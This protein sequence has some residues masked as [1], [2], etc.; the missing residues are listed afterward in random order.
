[1]K[2]RLKSAIVGAAALAIAGSGLAAATSALAAGP[3]WEPD[4]N[5]L[6]A[7]IFYDAAGNVLTGGT[8][9]SHIADFA[10]A[11]TAVPSDGNTYT[12]ANLVFAN[13]APSTPTGS[14][15][16]GAGSLNTNFPNTTAPAP[17][18][19][20]GFA[21]PVVTLGA[22]DGNLG[23]F[24]A[25]HTANTVAGFVDMY[26]VR[27]FATGPGGATTSPGYWE[28]DI[29][30]TRNPST[31]AITGWTVVFPTIATTTTSIS[32]TPPSPQTVGTSV[33]LNSTVTPAENGTV[34]F[35]DGATP[36]GTP[37]AV[38][39]STPNASVSAGTPAAGDHPYTAKFTPTGGTLV[40]G[41]TSSVLTYHIG[42]P[43]IT[44][45]T[46][47][48]V[49]PNTTPQFGSVTFTANITEADSPVTAGLAGSVNFEANGSSL[50]IVSTNDGT[51]GE[52]KL[53]DGSVALAPSGTPYNITAVFTP[54]NSAYSGST[55]GPLPLT[56]TQSACP[57]TPVPGSS[58]TDTQNV[59]VTVSAGSLTITTPYTAAKPFVI[60]AP[61]L[62]TAGTFLTSSAQFPAAG[63]PD[64]VVSSTLAS[65]PNWTVA[66]SGT[67]LTDASS[68]V[69]NGQNLGLT[70]GALDTSPG[71]PGTVSFTDNPAAS[72]PVAAAAPGSL[73]IK[74]GPHTFAQ[75]S[76]GGNGTAN[77]HGTLTLNLPT[78]TVAGTYNGTITFSVS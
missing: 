59:T 4:P 56:V 48:S 50:G 6:G 31:Q 7:V 17:I 24:A 72:P 53:V 18:T 49:N 10:A 52:Y 2:L 9:V 1:M 19:G 71:F 29:Q 35:F 38:T 23:T 45:S 43:Q 41:S 30:L 58:C 54:T 63:D 46:A 25:G 76:G 26:Q 65:D 3:P 28:T 47:L 5:S 12:K 14:F 55:G 21:N 33:T 32:A 39:T 73:G 42:A 69:I 8:N 15:S 77:L 16:T 57:G 44:T 11:S 68:H 74:G 75:S 64:I 22:S 13:P 36:V 66:V 67:D 37:Q 60:P 70:G 51:A 34:S 27:I 61:T 20:P 40:Q 62:N 78:A